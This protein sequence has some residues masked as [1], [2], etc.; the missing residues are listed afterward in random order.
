L[1]R[2]S[3][4]LES[5]AVAALVSVALSL[6][7]YMGVLRLPFY[8]DD[9]L[10]IPW[11]ASTPLPDLW[12]TS[13]PYQDYRPLHFTLWRLIYLVAGSLE[14]RSLHVLNLVGHALCGTLV[15]ALA[16]RWGRRPRATAPLAAALFV[17]FPFAFDAVPWAIAFSYPLTVVLTLG[18]LLAYQDAR[19]TNR[20]GIYLLAAVPTLLAGFSHES[21]AVAGPLIVLAELTVVR[22][23][24]GFSPRALVYPA[25]SLVPLLAAALVRP[26]GMA[27]H[28]L[29]WPDL[30]SSACLALQA[31]TFPVAPLAALLTG[32]GCSAEL[33]IALVG[34]PALAGVV[35][36]AREHRG[37]GLV[38]LALGWWGLWCLP[39]L[40]TLRF[41]W[42]RDAPRALYPT[43]VGAALLWSGL[44]GRRWRR[45][46]H[47]LGAAAVAAVCLAPASWF[48]WGRMTL[49]RQVGDLLWQVV[50]AAVDHEPLLVVNLPARVTP[51]ER[52]YPL[53]H[54]GVI[55][56]PL[57]P[58]VH[59][60]DLVAVHTGRSGT[61]FERSWGP[62][63]P[64]LP[65]SVDL[66][67]Q[68]LSVSDLRAAHQVALVTYQ[69]DGMALREAGAVHTA[70][71]PLD[72]IAILNDTVE[73]LSADCTYEEG[74]RI[75]LSTRWR[76]RRPVAGW[77]TI[78]AHLA[79]AEGTVV[80][81]A[82]GDPLRG[83]YPIP[84]W[85]WGEMVHDVRSFEGVPPGAGTVAVGMWD[86]DTGTRW[87][88]FTPA[89]EHL[90]D[91]AIPCAVRPP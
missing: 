5:V 60:D 76:I 85:E 6:A 62:V 75:V 77:P 57:P 32:A 47:P 44:A 73:L 69:P 33:A 18:A 89:G 53:G 11:V 1:K 23:Q 15:G 16:S 80:A 2:E 29:V 35:L 43:A 79:G 20:A 46:P 68:P 14:P 25:L 87:A 72:P 67:G 36:A 13:G 91:D 83:L 38:L 63:L 17:V 81:Q 90:P 30:L 9:L 71:P 39:P 56:M 50:D 28:G 26:Q 24:G 42:L 58:R 82:D 74:D 34:L 7:L 21:G 61:A 55:P 22:R 31:L 4:K 64:D 70:T 65:Y 48:V 8:S 52:F 86:P 12:H 37:T 3:R 78:F 49:Q 88:A 54:E 41:E 27:L 66:L 51:G 59:V 84:A 19:R 10:Q 40:L 45:V